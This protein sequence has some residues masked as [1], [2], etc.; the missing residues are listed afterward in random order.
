MLIGI[1]A[2]LQADSVAHRLRPSR[3]IVSEIEFQGLELGAFEPSPGSLVRYQGL[4]DEAP[5]AIG[6][7]RLDEILTPPT[8]ATTEESEPGPPPK[9]APERNE[10][11]SEPF[12]GPARG[13]N[14]IDEIF[15][16]FY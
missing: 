1:T 7:P 10:I 14:A 12:G 6:T 16:G 15:E 3:D 8:R 9:C 4:A 2:E 5:R 13:A 11:A